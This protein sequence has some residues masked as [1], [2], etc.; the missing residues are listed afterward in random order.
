M[1][2]L[3]GQVIDYLLAGYSCVII[4]LCGKVDQEAYETLKHNLTQIFHY[5]SGPLG[6]E[7][8]IVK[9]VTKSKPKKYKKYRI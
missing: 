8:K 6:D 2:R 3:V 7:E 4:V 9:I 1:N 5:F